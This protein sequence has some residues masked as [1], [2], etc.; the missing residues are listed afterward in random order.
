MKASV[1]IHTHCTRNR[2]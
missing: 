2:G 1:T